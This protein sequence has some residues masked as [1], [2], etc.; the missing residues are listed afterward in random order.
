MERSS[1]GASVQFNSF[2]R[3]LSICSN[4]GGSNYGAATVSHNEIDKAGGKSGTDNLQ[5]V[6]QHN[7]YYTATIVI[8]KD[9]KSEIICEARNLATYKICSQISQ[10]PLL[11]SN[12]EMVIL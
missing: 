6:R 1:Y 11:L 10:F 12:N 4:Y 3:C 2:S 5:V 7:R 9:T 8:A